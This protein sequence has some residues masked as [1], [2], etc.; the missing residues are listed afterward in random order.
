M[1]NITRGLQLTLMEIIGNNALTVYNVIWDVNE[2]TRDNAKKN[3]SE[4]NLDSELQI[5]QKNLQKV[6][7]F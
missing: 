2:M 3:D 7:F 4:S 6:S 1:D 5:V